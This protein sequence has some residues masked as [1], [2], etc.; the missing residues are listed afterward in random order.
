[1]PLELQPTLDGPRLHLRPLREDD[2]D[3]LYDVASDPLVWEQHPNSDRWQRSVFEGFFR[4]AMESRGA[5]VVIDRDAG[6]VVGSS[7]F[8]GY[9]PESSQVEI[10]WSF[11]ARSH[12]GGSYNREMKDLMLRHALQVVDRV[13]FLVGPNNLRSQKAMLK[14]G[15]QPLGEMNNARGRP[16][17][18]FAITRAQWLGEVAR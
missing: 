6:R 3:A 1:M 10:G 5:L 18:G 14:L 16:S 8:F 12:W 2:F 11:L 15:A 9:D 4:E 17:V 7:R 13:I